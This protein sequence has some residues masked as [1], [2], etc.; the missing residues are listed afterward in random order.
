MFAKT[1][2]KDAQDSLAILGKGCL[3]PDTYM[4]GGSALALHLGHRYS[5]DFD[6]FT[7]HEFNQQK[8]ALV[9]QNAGDFKVKTI[10]K[11]TLLGKFNGLDFS[12][13]QYNYPLLFTTIGF[14]GINLADPRDIAAMKIAAIMDRGTKKDFIDL[15]FLSTKGI[16]LNNCFKYYDKKYKVL[17]GNLYSLIMSLSYFVEAEES[18]M[19][20]MIKKVS[21]EEIKRFFEKEAVRLGKKYL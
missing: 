1:L 4:A 6:F 9:L 17:A 12:L 16:D 11:D 7:L 13:F 20:R 3:P 21:W 8:I 2:S 5:I 15:Y 10:K 19:P 18:E 14:K